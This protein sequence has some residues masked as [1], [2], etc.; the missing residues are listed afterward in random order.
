MRIEYESALGVTILFH[1]RITNHTGSGRRTRIIK[2]EKTWIVDEQN[3]KSYM[4]I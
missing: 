1:S 2:V 3:K 4:G